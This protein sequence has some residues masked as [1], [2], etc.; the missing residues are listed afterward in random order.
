MRRESLE[1]FAGS[2][3]GRG[4]GQG[5]WGMMDTDLVEALQKLVR[6]QKH[7]LEGKR[8]VMKSHI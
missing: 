5:P 4:N 7:E 8:S 1:D 2:F 6:L 3:L